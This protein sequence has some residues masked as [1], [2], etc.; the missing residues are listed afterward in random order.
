[1]GTLEKC[2]KKGKLAFSN[3]TWL[4]VFKHGMII[5]NIKNFK[6]K[7]LV[8]DFSVKVKVTV[9][10]RSGWESESRQFLWNYVRYSHQ[11][12]QKGVS[13][14]RP[15]DKSQTSAFSSKV[16]VKVTA[17]RWVSKHILPL[18]PIWWFWINQYT[19]PK[20]CQVS[21]FWVFSKVAVTLNLDDG[22]Q[23]AHWLDVP[24]CQLP[25]C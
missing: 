19:V 16:K 2:P 3:T 6:N 21:H 17:I 10:K 14:S 4:R 11:T 22:N 9:V 24:Y 1:M 7:Y 12:W 15:F 20:K 25:L 5:P 13:M 8:C 18:C 23:T